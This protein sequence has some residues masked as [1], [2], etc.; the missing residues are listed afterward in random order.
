[1]GATCTCVHQ[2]KTVITWLVVIGVLLVSRNL[3]WV[4]CWQDDLFYD[5]KLSLVFLIKAKPLAQRPRATCWP[6]GLLI[7]EWVGLVKRSRGYGER[8]SSCRFQKFSSK[9]FSLRRWVR[10][11]EKQNLGGPS[12]MHVYLHWSEAPGDTHNLVAA[13][14]CLF[15]REIG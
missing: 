1:M 14:L 4:S 15:V 12:R 2:S 13:N 11:R 5:R 9:A 6:A 7:I 3:W 10:R 8:E